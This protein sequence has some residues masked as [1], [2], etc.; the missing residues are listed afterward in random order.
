MTRRRPLSVPA[1]LLLLLA[2]SPA[3]LAFYVPGVAPTDFDKGQAIEVRAIKMT[4]THTQLPYDYYSLP[5]CEPKD[6]KMEYKSENLGEILRG[7][8]I[9]NTAYQVNMAEEVECKLLCGDKSGSKNWDAK[10]SAEVFYKIEQEY[11]L[12]LIIDNLPV[13]TQ[14]ELPGETKEMQ[15]EPGFRMGYLKDGK[16]AINNHLRLTLSY[17]KTEEYAEA[18]EYYR[19]V[20]FRV[21]TASVDKASYEIADDGGCSIKEGYTAQVVAKDAPTSLYFTYSVHWEPSNIRWASR[22][23]NY[24]NMAD[25]QIHW[26]SIINSVVVVFFLSGIITMI[27]IRTLRRDIARYNTDEDLEESI[28]ETGWKL[29]HGDVFRPPVH[30]RDGRTGC[31]GTAKWTSQYIY[32]RSVCVS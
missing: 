5:F 19:V 26:F 29:V 8:R 1:A 22:W 13:A 18:K 11:F 14:F 23:D 32:I 20:G 9:V 16:A 21:E 6:G 28:E 10:E 2:V 15:Y 3:A 4:S 17:H 24:L 31:Q 7:D 27:I 12:H 25:V 30:S